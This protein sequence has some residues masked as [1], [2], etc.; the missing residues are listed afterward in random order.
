MICFGIEFNRNSLFSE[1]IKPNEESIRLFNKESDNKYYKKL[2][3]FLT[4]MRAKFK[5]DENNINNKSEFNINKFDDYGESDEED[6]EFEDSMVIINKKYLEDESV[7]DEEQ[8][9]ENEITI[10]NEIKEFDDDFID[11]NSNFNIIGH[12][13]KRIKD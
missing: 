12:K 8:S 13:T 2:E 4:N 11:K 9:D 10:V 7:Y 6:K 1:W 3:D 5:S